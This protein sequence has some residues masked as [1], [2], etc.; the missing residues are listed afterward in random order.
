MKRSDKK[1][2]KAGDFDKAFDK[3]AD[4][5][6][7]LDLKTLKIQHPVRRINV[8]IPKQMLSRL[9]EEAAKIGVPRTSL[10][11]MWIADRLARLPA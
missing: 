4:V 7:Y 1:K 11:K 5:T 9:D 2:I 10:L 6:P 3:G 8:D